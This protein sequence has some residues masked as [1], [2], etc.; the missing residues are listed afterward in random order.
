MIKILEYLCDRASLIEPVL[1]RRSPE[2]QNV[3]N[4]AYHLLET[5]EKKLNIDEREMLNK[6]TDALNHEKII[7]ATEHFVRGYCLGALIMLEI[8]EKQEEL[9]VSLEK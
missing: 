5:L 8:M 3:C 6:A 2:H 9:I 7:Y 1:E 4:D